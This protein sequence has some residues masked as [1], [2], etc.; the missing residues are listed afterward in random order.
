[1]ADNGVIGDAGG[2]PWRIPEDMR[3]FR[4][5][6]LGK[7]CIMGRRTWDSLPKKPLDGRLNI[8]VTRDG[9][10]AAPG[11]TVAHGL[12]EALAVAQRANPSEVMVIGGADIYRAALPLADTL[13]LTEVHASIE[14][15]LRL[16]AFPGEGWVETAREDRMSDGGLRYS[17][18]RL[19]R[20]QR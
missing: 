20:G 4:Q 10:F 8:V 15:D 13:F 9:S 2:I 18:V 11:A 3:R 6:T 14:G 17:Y 19:D 12:D 5:L 1:M 7:P 16:T